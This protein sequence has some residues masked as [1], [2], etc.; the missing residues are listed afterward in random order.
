[1][2]SCDATAISGFS[3]YTKLSGIILTVRSDHV[4][5]GQA[6]LHQAGQKPHRHIE[7]ENFKSTWLRSSPHSV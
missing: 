3:K 7:F 5:V 1:M 2:I 4:S 6:K